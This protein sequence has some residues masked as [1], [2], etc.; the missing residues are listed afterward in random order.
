MS[1]TTK[2]QKSMQAALAEMATAAPTAPATPSGGFPPAPT[3]LPASTAATAA[4]DGPLRS[5]HVQVAP[6]LHR[7][8]KV[9]AAAQ[10]VSIRDLTTRALSDWLDRHG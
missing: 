1:K 10:G 6:D 9:A 4:Q 8:L 7:R 3:P 2:Q 5:I